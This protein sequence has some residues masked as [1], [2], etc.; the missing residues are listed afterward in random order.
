MWRSWETDEHGNFALNGTEKMHHTEK[1]AARRLR[2][3]QR[4]GRIGRY[5]EFD[6]VVYGALGAIVL[7]VT[8]DGRRIHGDGGPPYDAATAT[9]M[10]DRDF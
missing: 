2:K 4:Q 5:Q 10:Y 3:L 9:G 6:P 8:P 1:G 7:W